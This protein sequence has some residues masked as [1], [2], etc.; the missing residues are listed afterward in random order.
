MQSQAKFK[1]LAKQNG[2]ILV[3]F[4]IFANIL[5]HF[6]HKGDSFAISQLKVVFLIVIFLF[7]FIDTLL[8]IKIFEVYLGYI[9]KL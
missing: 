3:F 5:F 7:S 6:S 1:N 9:K 4:L 8:F 2:Q